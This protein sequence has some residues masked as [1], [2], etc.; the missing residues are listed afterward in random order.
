MMYIQHTESTNADENVG[1]QNNIATVEDS[2]SF[3]QN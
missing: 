3:S 2:C 1:M